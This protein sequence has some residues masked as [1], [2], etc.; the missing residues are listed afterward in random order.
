MIRIIE[1]MLSILYNW[2]K[3]KKVISTIYSIID[4]LLTKSES[5]YDGGC[6]LFSHTF[7]MMNFLKKINIGN[8]RITLQEV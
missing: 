1:D 5:P 8:I 3:C 7:F 2:N 6:S 4:L